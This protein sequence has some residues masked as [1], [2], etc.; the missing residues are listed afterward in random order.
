[1]LASDGLLPG[2]GNGAAP[3]QAVVWSLK[4][5]RLLGLSQHYLLLTVAPVTPVAPAV[6]EVAV[7]A[8][9]AVGPPLASPKVLLLQ[10]LQPL[11]PQSVPVVVTTCRPQCLRRSRRQHLAAILKPSSPLH[12]A[13]Q[14]SSSGC[15]CPA[16]MRMLH[17]HAIRPEAAAPSDVAANSAA[18]GAAAAA[19]AIFAND[20]E[21]CNVEWSSVVLDLWEI[22]ALKHHFHEWPV[23]NIRHALREGQRSLMLS[24][25]LIGCEPPCIP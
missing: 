16:W 17:L 19:A 10:Q 25:L 14:R 4:K 2:G 21:I 23:D 15:P 13:R 3:L 9:A 20:M 8:R 6:A 7:A 12:L 1:M 22:A 5:C 24:K 18:A 11:Q